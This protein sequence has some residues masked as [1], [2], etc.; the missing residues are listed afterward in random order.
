VRADGR[1]RA[2]RPLL[3]RTGRPPGSP[4]ASIETKHSN[5]SSN[6][7][8]SWYA[9]YALVDATFRTPLAIQAPNNPASNEDGEIAVE[10][11]DRIPRIP[12]HGFKLG[13][14]LAA[15][16]SR[17][18]RGDEANLQPPISGFAVVN[19]RAGYRVDPLEL[20]GRVEN[21]LGT[22]YETFGIFGEADE[23]GFEDPRFLSPGA[24]RTVLVGVR[25]RF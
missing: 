23:L 9:L 7:Q 4:R 1:D 10:R 13:A 3:P 15:T 17:R 6:P 2:I 19:A 5:S 14:E 24:P 25:G 16:S 20:F 11:G 22:R 12:R 8:G 18:L 21:V